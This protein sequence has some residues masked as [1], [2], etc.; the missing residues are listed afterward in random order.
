MSHIYIDSMY[1]RIYTDRHFIDDGYDYD[2]DASMNTKLQNY[3][4]EPVYIYKS[5]ITYS[6][7]TR[8]EMK[9]ERKRV[10]RV[11]RFVCEQQ[12]MRICTNNN[13]NVGAGLSRRR[14]REIWLC[15]CLRWLADVF[16]F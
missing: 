13:N 6:N 12:R 8:R 5:T 7:E 9:R 1:V 3:V 15:L 11:C 4:H 10:V 16:F 2:Y 14:E